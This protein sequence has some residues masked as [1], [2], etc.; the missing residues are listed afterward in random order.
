MTPVQ[1]VHA[2]SKMPHSECSALVAQIE[3][4]N[5]YKFGHFLNITANTD[6]FMFEYAKYSTSAKVRIYVE[7][8]C[9]HML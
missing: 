4:E 8:N 5:G 6:E 3:R 1:Y 2:D 7:R 9:Q